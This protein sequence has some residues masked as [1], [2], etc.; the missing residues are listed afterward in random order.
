M[1][2]KDLEFF[3]QLIVDHQL[4][5]AVEADMLRWFVSRNPRFDHTKWRKQME[6]RQATRR[7]ILYGE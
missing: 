2:K 4:S 5:S 1:T 7:E 6:K 3:N